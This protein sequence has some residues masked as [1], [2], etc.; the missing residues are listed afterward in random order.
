M[1]PLAHIYG[2]SHVA[3][4]YGLEEAIFLHALM[5]WY[6]TN[7]GNHQNFY[8]GRWWTYNSVKA[9]EGIFPW[10]NGGQIRRIIAR[11]KE[12][13]AMLAGNYSEDRRDRTAWY[14]PSDDLLELYGESENCICRKQQMQL[15]GM[16][17]TFDENGKCIQRNTWGNHG[18]AD[19]DNPPVVPQEGDAPP[20]EAE[21]APPAEAKDGVPNEAQH[22]GAD[23]G[24]PQGKVRS[25]PAGGKPNRKAR[26]YKYA[27]EHKPERFEQF[28]AYY[29][30]GG[31]RLRAVSAWDNLAPD[32]ALIDEMARALKRQKDTQQWQEGIGIPH[33]STW[34]NQRRWTDKLPE[35]VRPRDTGGWADDPER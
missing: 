31:S 9:F 4:A 7:R 17:E 34:L 30:G 8:D 32:D 18:G 3:A 24:S 21:S 20:T 11:C 26:R 35:P 27:P 16:A 14:T 23:G 29:P 2:E 12:K 25:A 10:W 33:A 1:T 28:W 13:G 19:M 15:A 5:F 22:S 6:R